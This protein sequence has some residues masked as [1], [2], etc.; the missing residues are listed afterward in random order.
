MCAVLTLLLMAGLIC[1]CGKTAGPDGGKKTDAPA[2]PLPPDTDLK[3]AITKEAATI[4]REQG[5][6]P[7]LPYYGWPSVAVDENDVTYV[8]VSKRLC[9]VDPYGKVMLYKSYDK[10]L[11]WDEG[12]CILDTILDDRDAGIVYIG[13][14]RLLV[15]SFSHDASQYIK[16]SNTSSAPMAV[17]HLSSVQN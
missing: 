2:T 4:S 11:S 14:G 15:T 7:T 12:T 16:N 8:V 3:L 10:G 9:H 17:K 6:F 13:G 5:S 1:S